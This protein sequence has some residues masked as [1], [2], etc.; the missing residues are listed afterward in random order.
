MG[1]IVGARVTVGSGVDVGIAVLVGATITTGCVVGDGA[2]VGSS[3]WQANP[4]HIA[5]IATKNAPTRTNIFVF[6]DWPV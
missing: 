6:N 2:G 5:L 4:N 3:P 1:D